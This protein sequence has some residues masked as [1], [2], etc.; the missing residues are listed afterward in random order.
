MKHIRLFTVLS[1]PLVALCSFFWSIGIASAGVLPGT[2]V[3]ASS[4]SPARTCAIDT[5]GG[6]DWPIYICQQSVSAGC[7]YYNNF[8]SP[9]C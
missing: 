5:V 6:Y 2:I 3:T 9:Y 8:I 1:A 7:K 4:T